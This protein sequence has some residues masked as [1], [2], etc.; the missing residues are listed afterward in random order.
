MQAPAPKEGYVFLASKVLHIYPSKQPKV[1][2]SSCLLQAQQPHLQQ[3][4]ATQE[5]RHEQN[6]TL[7][8]TASIAGWWLRASCRCRN[9]TQS[10]SPTRTLLHL[11]RVQRAL[12]SSERHKSKG[13][14]PPSLTLGSQD[15]MGLLSFLLHARCQLTAFTRKI[16]RL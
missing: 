15:P 4:P 7:V 10:L 16:Q 3:H 2:S 11:A 8:L 9:E 5:E 13:K 6:V 14:S 12:R 1:T